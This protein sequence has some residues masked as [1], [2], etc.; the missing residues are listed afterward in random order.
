MASFCFTVILPM[1]TKQ[2]P[3]RSVFLFQY[4]IFISIMWRVPIHGY[5]LLNHLSMQQIEKVV[6]LKRRRCHKNIVFFSVFLNDT[7]EVPHYRFDSS[8]CVSECVFRGDR[9]PHFTDFTDKSRKAAAAA[10]SKLCKTHDFQE[11]YI[12]Y[13]SPK[14]FSWWC[15]TL[16]RNSRL[17]YVTVF[18]TVVL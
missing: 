18:Y 8:E 9:H 3:K 13:I 7:D 12:H 2:A 14:S 6:K 11:N 15:L 17:H 10:P 16:S 4:I 5:R 1:C